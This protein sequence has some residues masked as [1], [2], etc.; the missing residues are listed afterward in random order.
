MKVDYQFMFDI[1]TGKG[2]S[3]CD[4]L[5]LPLKTSMLIRAKHLQFVS[6]AIL[7]GCSNGP[8]ACSI[9]L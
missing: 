3:R 6:V 4:D 9:L 5:S 2:S 8:M 7:A 1:V